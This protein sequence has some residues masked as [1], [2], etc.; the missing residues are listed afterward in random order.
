VAKTVK[1]R[2]NITLNIEFVRSVED[3]E[4]MLGEEMEEVQTAVSDAVNARV[5]KA[6]RGSTRVWVSR[7]SMGPA[8]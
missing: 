1:T 5:P 2:F 6:F 3:T 8:T 4:E 7:S